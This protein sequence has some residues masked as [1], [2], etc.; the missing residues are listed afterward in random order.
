MK[1]HCLLDNIALMCGLGTASYHHKETTARL[2]DA[3]R[4]TTRMQVVQI[5]VFRRLDS[6][7]QAETRS[8]PSPPDQ[9]HHAASSHLHDLTRQGLRRLARNFQ[10]CRNM[11]LPISSRSSTG[12]FRLPLASRQVVSRAFRK[13]LPAVTRQKVAQFMHGSFW[14]F[15]AELCKARNVN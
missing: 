3:R 13:A 6:E 5:Q 11:I 2:E 8:T 15:F 9:H 14:M 7:L 12:A 4:H 10:H 1:K